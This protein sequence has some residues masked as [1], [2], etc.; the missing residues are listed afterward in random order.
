MQVADAFR[1]VVDELHVVPAI[2]REV[3]GVEAEVHIARVRL[4]EQTLQ[5]AVRADVG[6]GVRVELLPQAAFL[7]R[8][9]G[10]FRAPEVGDDDDV[11]AAGRAGEG[12]DVLDLLGP[13]A[14]VPC[15][16]R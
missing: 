1:V 8:L 6:V 10:R 4:R 15:G 7:Q 5:L 14:P 9:A 2:V 12:C 11:L 3:A 13:T 16:S